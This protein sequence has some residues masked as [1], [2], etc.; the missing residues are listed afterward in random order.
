MMH[1]NPLEI[2][3]F[4][5]WLIDNRSK[6]TQPSYPLYESYDEIFAENMAK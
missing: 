1:D 4:S 5:P 6:E 3:S 2:A